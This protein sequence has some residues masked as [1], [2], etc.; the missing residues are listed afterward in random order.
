MAPIV[1]A[2]EARYGTRGAMLAGVCVMRLFVKCLVGIAAAA[3]KA[4]NTTKGKVVRRERGRETAIFCPGF[5]VAGIGAQIG[6]K[7]GER[8]RMNRG[9]KCGVFMPQ[10]SRDMSHTQSESWL[11]SDGGNFK[12]DIATKRRRVLTCKLEESQELLCL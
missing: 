6:E 8:L 12:A 4:H 1:H 9:G 2:E 11:L 10:R 7:R 3:Q 5:K